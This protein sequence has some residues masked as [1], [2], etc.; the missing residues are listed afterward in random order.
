MLIK[1]YH[2]YYFFTEIEPAIPKDIEGYS[3]KSYSPNHPECY[4]DITSEWIERMF[5]SNVTKK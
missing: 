3:Y 2:K 4:L 1:T 5:L